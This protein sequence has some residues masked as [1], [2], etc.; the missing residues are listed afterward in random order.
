MQKFF[1][2]EEEVARQS[3]I[4]FLSFNINLSRKSC[5]LDNGK[6]TLTLEVHIISE[7][8]NLRSGVNC[9]YT[10]MINWNNLLQ[11]GVA[12]YNRG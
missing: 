10:Y 8:F 3:L 6:I 1:R 7:L 5:G 2:D 4:Y 9:D 11:N 12:K